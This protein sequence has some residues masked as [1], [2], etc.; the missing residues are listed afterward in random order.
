MDA[1]PGLSG[2]LWEGW[3]GVWYMCGMR[4]GWPQVALCGSLTCMADRGRWLLARIYCI[5]ISD[6]QI[7][8]YSVQYSFWQAAEGSASSSRNFL[9]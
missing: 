6:F 7:L 5:R 2:L 3:V 4:N 1:L 8:L 9:M